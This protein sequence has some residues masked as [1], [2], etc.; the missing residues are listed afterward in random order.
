MASP[1]EWFRRKFIDTPVPTSIEPH[2]Q[3]IEDAYLSAPKVSGNIASIAEGTAKAV[4][5]LLG[6]PFSIARTVTIAPFTAGSLLAASVRYGTDKMRNAIN[7]VF[8]TIDETRLGIW[9]TLASPFGGTQDG[10]GVAK[11]GG[12]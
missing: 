11:A 10:R 1:F 12:H 7:R 3:S 8:G 9:K 6:L 5:G 2:M 4:G